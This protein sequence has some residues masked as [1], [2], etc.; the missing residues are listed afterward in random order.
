MSD[1]E[2]L[3]K[4][5]L[6]KLKDI[7]LNSKNKIYFIRIDRETSYGFKT[8]DRDIIKFLSTMVFLLSNEIDNTVTYKAYVNTEDN[9]Q[10]VEFNKKQ[11]I[12]IYN[13]I[14]YNQLSLWTKYNSKKKQIIEA[15]N[16]EQLDKVRIESI[17]MI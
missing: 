13:N 7:Y 15:S 4:E 14:R 1:L 2:T 16:L 12:D 6:K 8:T 11:I 10:L 5:K 9:E 3:K 17:G